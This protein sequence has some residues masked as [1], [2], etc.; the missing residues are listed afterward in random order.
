MN[1]LLPDELQNRFRAWY[2]NYLT[3]RQ[4]GANDTLMVNNLWG[5]ENGPNTPSPP[6]ATDGNWTNWDNYLT[7]LVSDINA[8]G[9]TTGLDMEL[10]NEPDLQFDNNTHY[11]ETW[12]RSFHY[13]R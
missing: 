3:I 12:G 6:P 4:F 11:L 1:K 10:W 7:Q 13:L 8:A 9:I 2:S 5:Q